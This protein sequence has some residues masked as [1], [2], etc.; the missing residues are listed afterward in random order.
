M[1]ERPEYNSP[2]AASLI[3]FAASAGSVGLALIIGR[4]DMTSATLVLTGAVSFVAA[5]FVLTFTK[6]EPLDPHLL[7][8]LPA[9][10][11]IDIATLCADLGLREDAWYLP[12]GSDRAYVVQ[13]IPATAGT[14]PLPSDDNSFIIGTQA[15]GVQIIPTGE[16]LLRWLEEK[17]ALTLPPNDNDLFTAIREVCE[18]TLEVAEHVEVDRTGRTIAV[19]LSGFRLVPGCIAVRSASPKC[20][21]MVGCPVCSLIACMLAKGSGGACTITQTFLDPKRRSMRLIIAHERGREEETRRSDGTDA[22]AEEEKQEKESP[23]AHASTGEEEESFP[24]S[25]RTSL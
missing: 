16:P 9:Q 6:G 17:N 20:C 18:D 22:G 24:A 13:V 10:G 11:T 21:T 15:D 1:A 12:P 14:V 5:V 4:G 19:T 8:L 7:S 23:A 3:L 2:Y 25:I